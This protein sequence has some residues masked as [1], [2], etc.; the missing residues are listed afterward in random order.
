MPRDNTENDG[1]IQSEYLTVKQ[2]AKILNIGYMTAAK[3]FR[4]MPG[5]LDISTTKPTRGKRKNQVLRIPKSVLNKF[6]YDRK[7]K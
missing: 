6:I 1:E 2:V 4:N 3:H 5:V 7:I